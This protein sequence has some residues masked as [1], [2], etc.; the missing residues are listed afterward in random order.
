MPSNAANDA[1]RRSTRAGLLLALVLIVGGAGACEE[2][3]ETQGRAVPPSQSSAPS[4]GA[5]SSSAATEAEFT[6]AD[7]VALMESHYQPAILAHDMLIRGDLKAFQSKLSALAKQELPGNAPASWKPNHQLMRDAARDA[8]K[9]ANFEQAGS[10]M[11]SVVQTCGV[12][13]AGNVKGPVYGSPKLPKGE[14]PTKTKMRSHQW[15]TE[16]LWE[17]VTGPWDD[18]WKR[19]ASA[20]TKSD[21]FSGDHVD[22][23]LRELEAALRTLGEEATKAS[24]LPE[25]AQVY[26]RLLVACGNCHAKAKVTFEEKAK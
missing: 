16:R 6:E 21:V 1:H 11:A 12:C 9:A 5:P 24:D 10:G 22:P 8:A 25:R 15:A 18:A 14:T 26:G 20:L 7:K 13:H 3:Q 4:S 23:E 2:K 17:G 19:G